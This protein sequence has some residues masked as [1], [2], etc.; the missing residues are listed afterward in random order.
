MTFAIQRS[1]PR[2][3]RLPIEFQSIPGS[4]E[5]SCISFDTS[6]MLS[7]YTVQSSQHKRSSL[8]LPNFNVPGE[9]LAFEATW[10]KLTLPPRCFMHA[11]GRPDIENTAETADSKKKWKLPTID[12]RGRERSYAMG[13]GSRVSQ[14]FTPRRRKHGR[15]G[16]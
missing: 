16:D 5:H 9:K 12:C 1:I 10:I 7:A 14:D 6:G 8:A 3:R 13:V 2:H 11:H 15:T 4:I